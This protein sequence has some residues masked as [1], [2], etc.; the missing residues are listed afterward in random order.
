MEAEGAQ[1][2]IQRRKTNSQSLGGPEPKPPIYPTREKTGRITSSPHTT[3]GF[4]EGYANPPRSQSTTVRRASPTG[5][6]PQVAPTG[7]TPAI[8]RRQQAQATRQLSPRPAQ[9]NVSPPPVKAPKQSLAVWLKDKHWLFLIGLGMISALV[10]WLVGS[11]VLAWGT[12]RYY[13]LRYGNPRTYQTDI[14][15]GHGGDSPAHPSHFIAMNLNGQAIVIELKAG[16]PAKI[17]SYQAPITVQDGG[18]SPV[19]LSF[20]DLIG[21]HKLDMIVDIH[22]PGQDQLSYFI[23]D[24]DNDQFRSPK[25]HE[26]IQP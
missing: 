9:K 17:V 23:N 6:A 11:A 16:D 4:D 22:L 20:K 8:P 1:T 5:P 19:T 25:P 13:D 12:Q 15:V 2:P 18:Q 24:P 26:S 14:V 3:D 21:H 10:L 7:P